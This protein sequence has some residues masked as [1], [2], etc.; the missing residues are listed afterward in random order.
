[1]RIQN[2]VRSV[3]LAAACVLSASSNAAITDFYE[4]FASGAQS[5]RNSNGASVLNWTASGGPDGAPM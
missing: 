5:W 3:A 1:M 2:V 4:T